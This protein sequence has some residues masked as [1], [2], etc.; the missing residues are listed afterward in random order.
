M[1]LGVFAL[2]QEEKGDPVMFFQISVNRAGAITGGYKSTIADDQR[3][4]AGQI[5][6]KTQRAAWRMGENKDTIFVTSIANLTQDV[7][8]IT[9]HFGKTR[10]QTWLLVRMPEP[11]AAGQ[12]QKLP[13]AP[14][15]APP[16]KTAKKERAL[17]GC[18]F[19]GLSRQLKVS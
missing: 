1:P 6:K 18:S 19:T 5:D 3:S 11:A 2:A 13:K 4:I 15:K 10:T 17:V 12:P 14:D 16:V 9:L 8:P 7:A